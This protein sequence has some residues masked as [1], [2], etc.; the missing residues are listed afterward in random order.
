MHR[1]TQLR[2]CM[3]KPNGTCMASS[4]HGCM[5]YIMTILPGLNASA[6]AP[7]TAIVLHEQHLSFAFQRAGVRPQ[8]CQWAF[9]R[10]CHVC[11]G[12]H[13]NP[14]QTVT[15]GV[16]ACRRAAAAQGGASIHSSAHWISY[17]VGAMLPCLS[18]ISISLVAAAHVIWVDL[19]N[20]RAADAARSTRKLLS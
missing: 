4:K 18:S 7:P 8:A 16:S 5:L 11:A 10:H 9:D 17:A 13:S 12:I 6:A 2:D 14:N 3:Y 20:L 19:V 1:H 15:N